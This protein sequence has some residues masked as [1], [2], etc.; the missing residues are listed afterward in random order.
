MK[1]AKTTVPI[2]VCVNEYEVKLQK[3]IDTPKF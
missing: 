1:A 2:V 3:M